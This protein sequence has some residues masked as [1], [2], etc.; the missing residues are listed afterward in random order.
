[1]G[2]AETVCDAPDAE[3]YV[4]EAEPLREEIREK[5]RRKACVKD[6]SLV[7]ESDFNDHRLLNDIF[8]ENLGKGPGVR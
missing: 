4:R 5:R 8:F 7:H 3:A 2:R 1:M 6:I